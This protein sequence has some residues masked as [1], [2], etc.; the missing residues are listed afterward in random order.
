RGCIGAG[1]GR[2]DHRGRRSR[3]LRQGAA[4]T[5]YTDC[6]SKCRADASYR[7]SYAGVTRRHAGLCN[8]EFY[9]LFL[10]QAACSSR[11]LIFAPT[12]KGMLV[13]PKLV[14]ILLLASIERPAKEPRSG[15]LAL[16]GA[17]EFASRKPDEIGDFFP[18][19]MSFG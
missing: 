14:R 3:R 8:G 17:P 9:R 1:A 13:G 5:R 6:V 4:R 19:R 15:V 12:S 10:R 7:R 2:E 18:Q 16:A 11:P